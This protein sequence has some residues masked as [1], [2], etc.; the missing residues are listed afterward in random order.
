MITNLPAGMPGVVVVQHMPPV[1]TA[2]LASR[3]DQYSRLRVT[4][5]RHG[6]QVTAGRVLV[7]PGGKHV[8][9]FRAGGEYRISITEHGKVDGHRPS[10]TVLMRS[11]AKCA[12]ADAVGALLTGMGRDGADGLLSMRNAGASTLA[13]DEATSVVWGMPGVAWAIGAAERLVPLGEMASALVA[14]VQQRRV[15]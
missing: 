11:I 15:V 10:V 2:T 13:Q 8:K 6:D 12:G 7:A 9:V 3:L 4:E 1:F 5:A 14:Q